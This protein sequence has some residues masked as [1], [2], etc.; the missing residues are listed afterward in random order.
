MN[1]SSDAV[2]GQDSHL[3]L[4]GFR[5]GCLTEAFIFTQA[6][7]PLIAGGT[8]GQAQWLWEPLLFELTM[9]ACT[10]AMYRGRDGLLFHERVA[11]RLRMHARFPGFAQFTAAWTLMAFSYVVCLTGM[12]AL[13]FTGQVDKLGTPWPYADTQVYD[14]DGLYD[15]ACQPGQKREGSGNW[16]LIRPEA[17]GP[18]AKG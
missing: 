11:P 16:D 13:R 15:A 10:L 18:C 3:D 6:P 12:G 9:L 5:M 8:T 1:A 7:G 4:A 14:P 2:A 17:V